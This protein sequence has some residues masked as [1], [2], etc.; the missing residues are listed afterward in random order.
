M[1]ALNEIL[2]SKPEGLYYGNRLILPLQGNFLKIVVNDDIITDF[3]PS[4]KD[5][6]ISENEG[7]TDIYFK[8][9]KNLKDAVSKYEA[10]KLVLVEKGKDIF[11]FTNH[12]KIVIY[13]EEKHRVK[14]EETEENI[15]FLE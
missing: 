14:I 13:L 1:A 8:Q 2:M 5:I 6:Y 4:S 12:K 9:F 7:Y 11:N 3:S 15:L 10:I